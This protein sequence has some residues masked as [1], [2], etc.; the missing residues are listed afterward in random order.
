MSMKVIGTLALAGLLSV[1]ALGIRAEEPAAPS[2]DSREELRALL[3]QL[4]DGVQ[5]DDSERIDEMLCLD[6]MSAAHLIKAQ[7]LGLVDDA[8]DPVALAEYQQSYRTQVKSLVEELLQQGGQIH[9]IDV[10]RVVSEMAD[11]AETLPMETDGSV[12]YPITGQGIVAVTWTASD[13]VTD[14]PVNR[15][16]EYWCLVPIAL[17]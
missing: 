1:S 12:A 8:T 5:R 11:A 10:S 13:S 9:E 2:N 16:G 15:I 4:V 3:E 7:R 6:W 17:P 14:I